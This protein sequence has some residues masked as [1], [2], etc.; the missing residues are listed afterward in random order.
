M[1]GPKSKTSNMQAPPVKVQDGMGV[2]QIEVPS[3]QPV[4]F[5]DVIWNEPGPEGLTVRFRFVAPEITPESGLE[6][7]E[8]TAADMLHLCQSYALPRVITS[9][10]LPQQIVISISD[11]PVEFGVAAPEAT[12]FFDAYSIEDG[13]CIWEMF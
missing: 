4:I 8:A 2:E 10:P 7:F 11:I 13:V 3:G 6:D 9:T 5:Q 1:T 12:Q